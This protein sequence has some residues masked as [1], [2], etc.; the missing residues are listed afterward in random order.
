MSSE[1]LQVIGSNLQKVAKDRT[2]IDADDIPKFEEEGGEGMSGKTKAGLGAAGTLALGYGGK[3]LYDKHKKKKNDEKE[4][5]QKK[6]AS[7]SVIGGNLQKV[8]KDP[9]VDPKG[10]YG[11]LTGAVAGGLGGKRLGARAADDLI[12]KDQG[13]TS[14]LDKVRDISDASGVTGALVGGALGY[15]GMRDKSKNK[16]KSDKEE[17]SD[18]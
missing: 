13:V 3:K 16:K 1:T 9:M 6:S 12:D 8:A 17:Q 7:L 10:A 5:G 18:R 11:A 14:K 2:N 4:D 15:E